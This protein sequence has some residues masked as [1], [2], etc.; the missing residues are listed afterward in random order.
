MSASQNGCT[1]TVKCFAYTKALLDLD[2]N[3]KNM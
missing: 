3:F 2:E 1:D